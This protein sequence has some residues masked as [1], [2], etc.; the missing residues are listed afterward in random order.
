VTATPQDEAK[1]VS[2]FI[3]SAVELSVGERAT[4]EGNLRR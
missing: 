1:S 4:I 3:R 2:V